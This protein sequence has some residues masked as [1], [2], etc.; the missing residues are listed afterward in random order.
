[1]TKP[2]CEEQFESL[3]EKIVGYVR[4][5]YLTFPKKLFTYAEFRYAVKLLQPLADEIAKA[6]AL[7]SEELWSY[8]LLQQITD[9]PEQR[10]F[11][12]AVD[13]LNRTIK[14]IGYD[15]PKEKPQKAPKRMPL[16]KQKRSV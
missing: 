3:W 4:K 13:D 12:K 1:M 8:Y 14:E 11:N 2:Q 10:I 9:L 5:K 6:R 7:V 15:A 16:A